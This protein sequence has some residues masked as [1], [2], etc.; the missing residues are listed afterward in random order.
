MKKVYITGVS[1]TGKSTIAK[2]L[3]KYKFITIDIDAIDGLCHW[4]NKQ[5]GQKAEYTIGIGRDW[6]DAH[7]YVCDEEKLKKLINKNKNLNVVVVGITANQEKYFKLFDKVFLLYC[8]KETFLKRLSVRNEGN[9]FGKEKSEQEQ[10][11][12]WYKGFQDR[13]IKLGAIPINTDKP[14]EEVAN[15]I[16]KK[17]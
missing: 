17:I 5:T 9:Y 7:E 15:E 13:M 1:G 14:L 4:Q 12:S 16:I 11:L 6:I 2:E 8:S 3:R 10:I